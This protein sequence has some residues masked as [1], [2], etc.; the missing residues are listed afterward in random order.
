MK[1]NLVVKILF[2]LFV[3]AVLFVFSPLPQSL[4]STL[5]DIFNKIAGERNPDSSLI[6][7]HI[8]SEDIEQLGPWPIKRSYYALLIRNLNKYQVSK[9]GLEVF[10][11]AKFISQ[12]IYDNVLKREIIKANNVV[13]SSLAGSISEHRNIYTTD[14]LSLPSP[15]LLDERIITGHINFIRQNEIVVPLRISNQN[16]IEKAFSSQLLKTENHYPD[17]I[18]INFIS[19]WKKFTQYSLIEFFQL[20]TE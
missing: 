6:I 19:S 12:G 10:L 9:I 16:K 13:L 8:N 3:S 14:S 11:S 15:K 2:G 1:K 17:E 4:D 18:K 20:V 5:T 7:I